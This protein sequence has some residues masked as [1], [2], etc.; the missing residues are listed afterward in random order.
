M[1]PVPN[2]EVKLTWPASNKDKVDL[3]DALN[4]LRA[5]MTTVPAFRPYQFCCPPKALLLIHINL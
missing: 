4:E 3:I 5:N 1:S 2:G